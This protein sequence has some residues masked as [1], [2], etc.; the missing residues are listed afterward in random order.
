MNTDSRLQHDIQPGDVFFQYTTVSIVRT[1][2]PVSKPDL[3]RRL[4]SVQTAWIMWV[5]NF[6][7]LST[8]ASM[9]LYDGSP[10]HPRP[11]VLLQLA[12]ELG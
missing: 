11:G 4:M 6:V 8:G 1:Y 5:I 10:F 3:E 2:S 12:E 7:N 9:M